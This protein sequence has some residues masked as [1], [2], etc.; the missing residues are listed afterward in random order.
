MCGRQSYLWSR[1][2][3]FKI[4]GTSGAATS[5][6]YVYTLVPVPCESGGGG[7]SNP[8]PADGGFSTGPHQIGS[9]GSL[10]TPCEKVKKPFITVPTL[11]QR[12]QTLGSQTSQPIEKGFYMS[13][14]ANSTTS[15]PFT[16]LVGGTNGSVELPTS[17]SAPMSVIAHT[18]NSPA[19]STYSV[20]S[21]EDLDN[22]SEYIQQNPTF[23]DTENLVFIVITADGT[24]YALAI[25]D[26]QTFI[27]FFYW[28][29]FDIANYDYLKIQKKSKA[30]NDYY[31]GYPNSD[32]PVEPKIKENNTDKIQDLK[33]YLNMLQTNGVGIDVFEINSTYNTLTQV[34]YDPISN[35][36]IRT[37]C[38]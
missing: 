2:K 34:S 16:D 5:G 30:W 12:T 26:Y 17:V 7:I 22:L 36:I 13:N 20:P 23:V 6:E 35:Q 38:N 8:T 11:K 18:H 27:D 24:R 25:N 15:N 33:H 10:Q 19:N 3:L 9:G 37:N 31:L 32:P 4:L 21:W 1:R 29:K 14:N 28:S